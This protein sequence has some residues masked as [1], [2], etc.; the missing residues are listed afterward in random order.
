M[1]KLFKTESGSSNQGSLLI[2]KFKTTILV[3]RA[4]IPNQLEKAGIEKVGD[5]SP[6][7]S[8][9]LECSRTRRFLLI[10]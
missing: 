10:V 6:A 1:L 7:L 3:C 8:Q 4:D 5:Y 9:H 2:L